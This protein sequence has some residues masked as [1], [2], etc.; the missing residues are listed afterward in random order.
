MSRFAATIAVAVLTL[1]A[2]A[3]ARA[4]EELLDTITVP[5]NS[6]TVIQGTYQLKVGTRYVIEVSGTSKST[7]T[8]GGY[9]HGYDALYC[10]EEYNIQETSCATARQD[11]RN[12]TLRAH[13]FHLSSGTVENDWRLAD[14]F[15]T[16]SKPYGDQPAVDY[17]PNHSYTLGFYPPSAGP[18]KARTYYAATGGCPG[19]TNSTTGTF[20]VKVFGQPETTTPPPS[21]DPPP[22]SP[23][24]TT[25][26]EPTCASSTMVLARASQ[27]LPCGGACAACKKFGT[28]NVGK[29]PEPNK[30]IQV[31]DVT[32]DPEARQILFD[33]GITDA[34]S[35]QLIAAMILQAKANRLREQFWGC[36]H[37][38][39][40]AP[41]PYQYPGDYSAKNPQKLSAMVVACSKMIA[42]EAAK[43]AAAGKPIA[44]AS[45]AA[46]CKML[47]FPIYR[48]AKERKSA[49]RRKQIGAAVKKAITGGCAASGGQ[50]SFSLKSK[51]KGVP[52]YKITNRKLKASLVRVARKGTPTPDNAKL[53]TRWSKP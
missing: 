13:D 3:P 1:L 20:T 4:A 24:S 22:S 49:K 32:M 29:A 37:I 28:T 38:G 17:D 53:Y 26:T 46:N 12:R 11:P 43:E 35:Q 16:T 47:F 45:R 2:A 27:A 51:R 36:L 21:S 10:Y 30:P 31:G 44:I 7:N 39:T 52:L 33:A 18:I 42:D 6:S 50:L 23:P 41:D 8:D 34:A 25:P 15:L 48:N 40:L 5:A 9:G 14:Q 19:C